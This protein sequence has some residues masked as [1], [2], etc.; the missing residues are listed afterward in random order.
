MD[1]HRNDIESSDQSSA[2]VNVMSTIYYIET[3]PSMIHDIP[4]I[5]IEDEKVILNKWCFELFIDCS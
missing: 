1:M 5:I 3:S 2:V 4:G